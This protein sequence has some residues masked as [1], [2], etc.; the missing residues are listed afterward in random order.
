MSALR[1]AVPG[2]LL[3][4]LVILLA[5]GLRRGDPSEIPSPLVGKPMPAFALPRLQDGAMVSAEQ[6]VGQP[7]LINFWASWCTGCQVEHPL[8]MQLARVHGVEIVG[9]DYK[10]TP[11]AAT[12]WLARHGNPYQQVLRDDAGTA[13]LDFGVYGVPETFVVGADGQI[14]HKH[15]GPLTEEAWVQDIAPLL[16][17]A[18]GPT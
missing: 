16:G 4:A 14:L 7:R 6:L 15:V 1:Y 3:L 9:M 10:D 17:A 2:L 8:L 5:F 18:R 12:A 13:G 11:D